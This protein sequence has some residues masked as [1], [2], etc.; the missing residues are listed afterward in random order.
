LGGFDSDAARPWT[1]IFAKI[2]NVR[3]TVAKFSQPTEKEKY[4]SNDSFIRLFLFSYIHFSEV[5]DL[6]KYS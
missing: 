2:Q 5:M 6:R 3:T 1:I 4:F